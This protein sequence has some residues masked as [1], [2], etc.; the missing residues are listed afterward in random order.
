MYK[1]ELVIDKSYL[2]IPAI[3]IGFWALYSM[4]I[5]IPARFMWD[6]YVVY[7]AGLQAY[8][9]PS[10]LYDVPTFLY[11]PNFAILFAVILT[12]FPYSIAYY[13]LLLYN[14]IWGVLSNR[15]FNKILILIDVRKKIHRFIFLMIISNG[16]FVYVQFYLNQTKYLLFL[17]LLFI[18]RR[19]LQFNKEQKEK[20][21]QYYLLNYNLFI[22]AIGIAPQCIFYF[23]IYIFYDIPYNE[24][25]KKINLKKYGLIGI[26][27]AIQNI[28]FI[29]FP[30]LIFDFLKG[31]QYLP[32]AAKQNKIQLLYLRDW[33]NISSSFARTLNIISLFVLLGITFSLI[34]NNKLQIQDKFGYFSI[35]FILIG[36]QFF[37][38]AISL[39]F[40]SLVT[41]MFAPH[42][43]QEKSGL[44]FIKKNKILLLGLCSILIISFLPH[45]FIIY[46]SIIQKPDSKDSILVMID[47]L[48]WIIFI[49]LMITSLIL[50]KLNINK[51]KIYSIFSNSLVKSN[52]KDLEL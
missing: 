30:H 50:L 29:L 1:K 3:C 44:E 14:Y 6:Y 45:E 28:F 26:F 4:Y 8:T 31:F 48:R 12:I 51:S 39:I 41:L 27:S 42:I 15:E 38:M 17:I 36:V 10:N 7:H 11:M 16:F 2:I 37:Q 32:S 19:E 24:I 22:L 33:V 52:N 25:F 49:C 46:R 13:I 23:F 35:A 40:Y 9:D 34:I 18:I 5:L 21:L 43:S 20:N 47:N